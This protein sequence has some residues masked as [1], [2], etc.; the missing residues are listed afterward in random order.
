MGL[1]MKVT[2]PGS[3]VASFIGT[4]LSPHPYPELEDIRELTGVTIMSYPVTRVEG[5]P[6]TQ[7]PHYPANP[8]RSKC[9]ETTTKAETWA[10]VCSP[11][12]PAT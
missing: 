10:D 9:I 2:S 7:M 6:E 12:F 4:T 5:H 1:V 3:S 8:L 11:T